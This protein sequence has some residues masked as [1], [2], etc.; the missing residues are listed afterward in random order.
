MESWKEQIAAIEVQRKK[1]RQL[2]QQLYTDKTELL[3]TEKA[4]QQATR[5]DTRLPAD[6][7]A[8][9]ALRTLIAQLQQELQQLSSE[10]NA[11]DDFQAALNDN[12][13]RIEFLK[14]KLPLP[15]IK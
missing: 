4:L 1:V 13:S 3:K 14:R 5:G 8:I 12:S 2:D 9:A 10:M 6:A 15:K 7:Q 11:L